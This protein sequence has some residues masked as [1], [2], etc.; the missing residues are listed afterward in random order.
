MRLERKEEYVKNK[1]TVNFIR[2]PLIIHTVLRRDDSFPLHIEHL[3]VKRT[4][5][6][7]PKNIIELNSEEIGDYIKETYPQ[8]RS[9][10]IQYEEKGEETFPICAQLVVSRSTRAKM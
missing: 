6:N 9:F 4:T 10:V 8:A 3:K 7:I 5:I 1:G 2:V